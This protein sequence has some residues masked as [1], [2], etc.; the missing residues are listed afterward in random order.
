MGKLPR[1]LRRKIVI[2][3][4]VAVLLVPA[5]Y[6]RYQHEFE[7]IVS[8]VPPPP[9]VY[10]DTLPELGEIIE[11]DSEAY[12]DPLYRPSDDKIVTDA[13]PSI[14]ELNSELPQAWT[15]SIEN[16]SDF[17]E[18]FAMEQLLRE[19]GY[20]AYVSPNPTQE[21]PYVV[22]VGPYLSFDRIT[23]IRDQIDERWS[24]RSQ[25]VRFKP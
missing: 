11:P 12:F 15:L 14:D 20:T 17:D 13:L 18:A 7:P 4:A 9:D 6:E 2:A 25:I 8:D 10:V 19:G 22:F 5:I 21:G 1:K 16:F 3:I 23:E 24:I